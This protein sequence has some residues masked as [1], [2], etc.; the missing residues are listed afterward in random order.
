[1]KNLAH[2]TGAIFYGLWGVLHVAGGIALFADANSHGADKMLRTMNNGATT[3]GIP[4]IPS[5]I[6]DGLA[7]FHA[8]NLAWIGL[9]VT[10]IAVTMNW[11]NNRTG[12]WL[13]LAIVAAADLGLILFMVVPGYMSLADS[14]PGPLLFIPAAV[15][16]TIGIRRPALS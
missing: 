15:F 16:A 12:Y 1:M 6:A 5:G 11:R 14:W 10:V 9:L 4:A 7:E 13:N 3:G 2:R 8:F